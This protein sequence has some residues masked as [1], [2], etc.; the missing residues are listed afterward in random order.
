MLP[1]FGKLVL[2]NRKARIGRNP[3]TGEPIKI[4]AKRVCKFRL[5]K[6]LKDTVLGK[7]YG[8]VVRAPDLHATSPETERPSAPLSRFA[9]TLPRVWQGVGYRPLADA[10]AAR[11]L[12]DFAATTWPAAPPALAWGA[13]AAGPS[14]SGWSARSSASAIAAR[15]CS[16][17]PSSA[18]GTASRIRSKSPRQLV[19]A[20]IDHAAA[21]GAVTLYARPQGPRPRLGALRLHP[22]ARGGAARRR[23]RAARASASTRGAAAAPSGR[24]A[25]PRDHLAGAPT[26]PPP[27]TLGSGPAS[28]PLLGCAAPDMAP[29]APT[30]RSRAR[31]VPCV[32]PRSPAA[33][34]PPSCCAV[35]RPCLA[36]ARADDHRQHRRRHRGVGAARLA[37]SRLP[38]PTR[39]AACSTSTAAGAAPTRRSAAWT[40]WPRSAPRPGSASAIAT[41]P[42]T[43][44]APRTA[45]R[46]LAVGG[47]RATSPPRSR[48]R[49]RACCR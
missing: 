13:C 7:K 5:A 4:P 49:C 11:A 2:A 18:P 3:Q 31:P 34:V 21:L 17:G 36:P 38:S 1:G 19:A 37:R 35:S 47:H 10:A 30:P 25:K 14:A 27:P 8:P 20:A 28:R 46:R 33:P 48:R 15:S 26:W 29:R 6:S 22:R 32:S 39:W 9:A 41:L 12:F 16:T 42:P 45:R 23:W 24:C 40:R 43:S 44:S